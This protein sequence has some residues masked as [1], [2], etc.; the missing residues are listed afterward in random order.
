MPA[1][2]EYAAIFIDTVDALGNLPAQ[3]HEAFMYGKRSSVRTMNHTADVIEDPW[4]TDRG[5]SYH[6]S[7]HSVA[8]KGLESQLGGGDVTVPDERYRQSGIFLDPGYHLPVG[9]AGIHLRAS[10]SVDG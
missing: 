3:Q 8:V 1:Y 4:G 9:I 10:A 6:N 2:V 5:A 7:V